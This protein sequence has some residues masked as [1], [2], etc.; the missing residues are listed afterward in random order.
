MFGVTDGIL[1]HRLAEDVEEERRVLHVGITRGRHRVTV[2]ADR[3][4]PSAFLD[5]LAG[6]A[7]H[8]AGAGSGGDPGGTSTGRRG[9]RGPRRRSSR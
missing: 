9:R 5:E 3:T 6:T 2:L 1:P 4:R 7:P 8:H